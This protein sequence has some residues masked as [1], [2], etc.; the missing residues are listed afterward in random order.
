MYEVLER[1][2]ASQHMRM[3]QLSKRIDQ[4]QEQYSQPQPQ[5]EVGNEDEDEMEIFAKVVMEELSFFRDNLAV[6]DGKLEEFER[7][8]V[9]FLEDNL[10]FHDEELEKFEKEDDEEF[11][12]EMWEDE[13]PLHY[14][15]QATIE[16]SIIWHPPPIMVPPRETE[17]LRDSCLVM[18]YLC[19]ETGKECFTHKIREDT[20][21][22]SNL[23][24][25][26]DFS[27]YTIKSGIVED[28]SVDTA[29]Y[30]SPPQA[31]ETKKRFPLTGTNWSSQ[32]LHRLLHQFLRVLLR[33]Q[34]QSLKKLMDF[35]ED[36]SWAA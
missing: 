26:E 23:P 34:L 11:V 24:F 36:L 22:G 1:R 31:V 30:L 27:S 8:E 3:I 20:I 5:E 2:L 32:P 35:K 4:L 9:P 25:L 16:N 7:E 13:E 10:I 17:T 33:I 14:D 21:L 12:K 28:T 29:Y 15:I 19:Q 6:Q 18:K